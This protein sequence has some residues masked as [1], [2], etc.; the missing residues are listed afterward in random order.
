MSDKNE[1]MGK[2]EVH[3]GSIKRVEVR[4][5]QNRHAFG[6]FHYCD[7]AIETDRRNGLTVSIIDWVIPQQEESA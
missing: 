1:C 5:I 3:R 2:C 6:L 4:D 7:E